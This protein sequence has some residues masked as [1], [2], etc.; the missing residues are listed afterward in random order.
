MAKDVEIKGK[1]SVETGSSAKSINELNKE[2]A[3]TKL[4]LKD[5]KIGSEEHKSALA[6]LTA[7]QNELKQATSVNNTEQGKAAGVFGVLKEKVGNL[8]PALK[9]AENG[10]S[11]LNTGFKALVANP[12]GLILLAI[13]VTLTALYKAFTNTFE[14]GQKVEQ[15]FA[16]IKAAGQAL[17]DS[18][19]NVGRAIKKVFTLDFS[20]ARAEIKSVGT[21]AVDAYNKVAN[22]TKQAQQLEREQSQN[23]LDKVTRDARIAKL[24]EQAQDSNVSPQKRKQLAAELLKVSE[25]NAK[26][27]LA[28]A[29]RTADNKI[30]FLS[31]GLDASKKNLV[32]INKVKAEQLQGEIDNANELRQIRKIGNAADDEIAA[33]ARQAA[34]E[35]N[36]RRKE[37]AQKQKEYNAE[38]KR[39]AEE[40]LKIQKAFQKSLAAGRAE[41]AADIKKTAELLN[42]QQQEREKAE[43]K[44][45][46]DNELTRLQNKQKVAE[47]NVL[48][49]PTSVQFKIDKINADLALELNAIAQGDLQREVLAKRASNAIVAIRKEEA[50]AKTE[51]ARL[52]YEQK[53]AQITETGNLIGALTEIVGKQTAVGK[54]LAI[55]Q[56][57]INT[58]QGATEALRAKSTLPSPFDVVAKVFNVAA[59]LKTGFKAV[60]AITAV[61]IPGGGGGGSAS[62]AN[63]AAPLS[64]QT[65]TTGLNQSA[66]NGIGNAAAG[67][68]NRS[69]VLDSDIR[70]NDERTR[71]INRAARIS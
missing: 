64:P 29:K 45:L 60:K 38:M 3:Q 36:A 55:A 2:I 12:I 66:I 8:V 61:P 20:G 62:L 6:Q 10:A 23:D 63:I 67:G 53:K 7:Q 59:V 26:D 16:G 51:I 43:A 47:L 32:E 21:A 33:N 71:R 25:Q 19:A 17:I 50:D 70:S 35:A 69:F 1:I 24:K 9:G 40:R 49:D 54:G 39:L 14:G 42:K 31:Q 18:L 13:V 30:A 34:S 5:A 28:L 41:E 37:N 44:R 65:Q 4:A 68:T 52:E 48:E 15:V 56:S 11:S 27:D 57:L 58:Y 22:L 46:A